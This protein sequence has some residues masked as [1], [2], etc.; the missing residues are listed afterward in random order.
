MITIRPSD[1]RGHTLIDWLN[2]RHAFSFGDYYDSRN[3]G[4]GDL[5]VINEDHI[6]PDSGF[7][8]HS[9]RNMEIIT[10]VLEGEL[11]HRDSL[12]TGSVIRPGEVQRMSAGD[13][14]V[15]SEINPSKTSP[16]H[17]LQIWLQ[18]DE[19]GIAP[20]YEQKPFPISSEHNRLHLV[21]SRDGR[22]GS[23]KIHQS[24]SV[25]AGAL[26]KGQEVSM[27]LA[28]GRRAWIQVARG[29]VEANGKDLKQGDAATI[30]E[31]A[32]LTIR[33]TENAEVIVF[34]LP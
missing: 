34:D 25:Y 2:S 6:A 21:A 32:R 24:A 10:Y 23:L 22:E 8:M 30:E 11:Q 17:L 29:S 28:E 18:P 3:M 19:D 7:G 1:S 31:E 5:V 33:A 27:H 26:D 20:E 14:I 4:F 9:H 13:G 12:G 15:H 16:V